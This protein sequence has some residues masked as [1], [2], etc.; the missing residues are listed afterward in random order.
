[1][2][3]RECHAPLVVHAEALRVRRQLVERLLSVRVVRCTVLREI[4]E[5]DT[6]VRA[7]FS[8][9]HASTLEQRNE[10]RSR[11]VEK[12]RRLLCGEFSL[13]WD[14]SHGISDGHLAEDLK[15]EPQ[16]LS[17]DDGVFLAGANVHGFMRAMRDRRQAAQC[18]P[19]LF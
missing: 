7:G 9:R 16:R 3:D 4:G 17:G 14:N 5:P 11:D 8:I 18:L 13:N 2:D 15:Q 10:V 1:M 6:P 19:R 12:V